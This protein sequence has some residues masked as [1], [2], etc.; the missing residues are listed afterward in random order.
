MI[1]PSTVA[2]LRT[3]TGEV[4][5]MRRAP[6]LRHFPNGDSLPGGKVEGQ[7]EPIQALLREVREETG[8]EYDEADVIYVG[9]ELAKASDGTEFPVEVYRIDVLEQ[10]V[11]TLSSEHVGYSWL[12]PKDAL[13]S[14]P[15]AGPMTRRI[16]ERL[17]FAP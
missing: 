17:A 3:P 9:A 6:T 1:R 2:I 15:L 13:S 5:L 11:P 14:A 16:L 4:L 12:T 7:E 10:R 8:W